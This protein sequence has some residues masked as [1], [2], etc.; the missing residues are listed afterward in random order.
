M[1]ALIAGDSRPSVGTRPN[2]HCG[3]WQIGVADGTEVIA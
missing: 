3:P 1:G 2:L